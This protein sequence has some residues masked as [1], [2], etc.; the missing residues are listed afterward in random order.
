MGAAME[1]ESRA[2]QTRSEVEKAHEQG[3]MLGAAIMGAGFAIVLLVVHLLGAA[4][5]HV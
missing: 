1:V 4:V 5:R 3:F 2:G